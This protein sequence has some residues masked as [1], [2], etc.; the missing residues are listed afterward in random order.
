[1][2]GVVVI[3]TIIISITSIIVAVIVDRLIRLVGLLYVLLELL[4]VALE[5]LVLVLERG[6]SRLVVVDLLVQLLYDVLYLVYPYPLLLRSITI[7]TI[8]T[9]IVVIITIVNHTV[10]LIL[11]PLND[12]HQLVVLPGEPLHF[13][14]EHSVLV[15]VPGNASLQLELQARG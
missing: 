7:I 14:L 5:P 8:I 15:V 9:I 11:Q 4:I 12:L 6:Q 1:M 3:R 10:L 2:R 13:I